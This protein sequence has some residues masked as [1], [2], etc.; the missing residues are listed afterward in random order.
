MRSAGRSA[1]RIH[2]EWTAQRSA[3]AIAALALCAAF[4][5]PASALAAYR[6]TY[7]ID[8]TFSAQSADAEVV[9][10]FGLTFDSGDNLW[11]AGNGPYVAEFGYGGSIVTTFGASDANVFDLGEG[12]DQ[13]RG[14]A[15]HDTH[16]WL[17]DYSTGVAE[18]STSGNFLGNVILGAATPFDLPESV[19]VD[20]AGNVFVGDRNGAGTYGYR[21]S[22]FGPSGTYSG[23]HFGDTEGSGKYL[24]AVNGIAVANNGDV[25]VADY[26]YIRRYRPNAGATAY[27]L[28][29]TWSN[30]LFSGPAGIT[31]QHV[32]HGA[33]VHD[34]VFVTDA[35]TMSVTKLDSSN[36]V[37]AHWTGGTTGGTFD[38]P[39]GIAVA[40]NGNIFVADNDGANVRNFHLQDLGPS[41]YASASL[42]VKKGKSVTFKYEG[43]DDVS[44][45]LKM[46]IKIY[47]GSSLKKTISL[48]SVSQNSWH[49]KAWKC[50][51]AK[52]SYTWKVY[53]TDEMLQTQRNIASKTLKVK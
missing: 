41:T 53:A 14:V 47:K 48:G 17:C 52:G 28:N 25:Y 44:D 29:A 23:I 13:V 26:G 22:K 12:L 40:L 1:S 3:I 19:A 10:P 11:L 16:V 21:I 27:T 50:T 32:V 46:T 4:A 9:Q 45:T 8:N 31:T 37:L 39:K 7:L 36:H 30:S 15:I 2:T 20:A 6:Q 5:L 43:K 18:Y 42:T 51:L 33:A 35:D 49:T 24:Q 38:D 34:W